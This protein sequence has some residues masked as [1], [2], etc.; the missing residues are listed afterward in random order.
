MSCVGFYESG[1]VDL[2]HRPPA[3]EAG[4]LTGLRY[5]P[6]NYSTYLMRIKP[7][8]NKPTKTIDKRLKY[9]SIKFL[10]PSPKKN[11]RALTAK[12]LML[13]PI[14]DANMNSV[15][16]AFA[17]PAEIVKTL[18]GMGVRAAVNTAQKLYLLN[19]SNKLLKSS[20]A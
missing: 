1:R 3:P 5:A 4:A 12:N 15:K 17:A 13:L 10:I 8:T 11:I 19:V 9:L 7:P 6:S 20:S 2:N 18:Y 16:L 14:M